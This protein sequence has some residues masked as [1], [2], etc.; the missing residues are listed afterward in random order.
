[1]GIGI[2]FDANYRQKVAQLFDKTLIRGLVKIGGNT[3]NKT[4]IWMQLYLNGSGQLN[5]VEELPHDAVDHSMPRLTAMARR[6]VDL[7]IETSPNYWDELPLTELDDDDISFSKSMYSFRKRRDGSP[8]VD[9]GNDYDR[10]SSTF[11]IYRQHQYGAGLG[12]RRRTRRRTRQ[13]RDAKGRFTKRRT[14]K[15]RRKA[16][17]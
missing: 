15:Q 5:I 16:R 9:M 8:P 10:E 7:A 6:L 11:H 2:H 4:H 13:P 12:T 14:T 1:M 17:R 3:P